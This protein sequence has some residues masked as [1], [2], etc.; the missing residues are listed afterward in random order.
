MTDID[1]KIAASTR[2]RF[3]NGVSE[4]IIQDAESV[5]GITFP[6]SYRRWLLLYGAGY[7]DG[8]E[9]QGLAPNAPSS[10]NPNE[11]FVGDVVSTT[12]VNRH[13]H[14]VP[15]HLIELL[16]Y[17][18]DEIYFLDLSISDHG[19]SPVVCI[20]PG[21]DT[22]APYAQSFNEFLERQL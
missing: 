17:D 7:I 16:N 8:Y 19:E 10:R 4:H 1:Q 3:G 20:T 13:Q 2:A 21:N 12:L 14:S 15:P 22:P 5:L 9:L 6:H 11:L 18:G